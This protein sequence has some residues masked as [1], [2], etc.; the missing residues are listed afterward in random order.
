LMMITSAICTRSRIGASRAGHA[1]GL[2]VRL[3][4]S[5]CPGPRRHHSTIGPWRLSLR[6]TRPVSGTIVTTT[7][8][9]SKSMALP[10]GRASLPRR[11][12]FLCTWFAWWVRGYLQDHFHAVRL[13]CGSHPNV[14]PDLPLI[15]VQNHP[16]W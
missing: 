11:L 4:R 14:P 8:T 12:D 2:D 9:N 5:R 15:V 16:S 7:D 6:R 3:D 10:L 1:D 13:S